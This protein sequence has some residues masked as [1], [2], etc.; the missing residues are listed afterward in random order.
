MNDLNLLTDDE[1][2]GLY[3]EGNG[4]AFDVLLERYKAKLYAYIVFVVRNRDVA[5]DVFQDTFVKAI[6]TLK[7]GKYTSSGKFGAWLTRIAHNLIIDRFRQDRSDTVISNDESEVDLFNNA[8]LS[9]GNIE[10]AMVNNQVLGDVRRLVSMLPQNQKEVVFMRYY[11]DLSFKEIAEIT[12]VSINTALGRMR[13][14][15]MNI[16]KMASEHNVVLTLG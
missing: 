4:G 15:L 6:V 10:D 5:D 2:V 14:A 7:R 8:S 16:R 12:G 11:Q 9:E 13:Y 3:S 1:L